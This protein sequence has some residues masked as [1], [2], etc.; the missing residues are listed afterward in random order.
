VASVTHA[1]G[2]GNTDRARGRGDGDYSDSVAAVDGTLGLCG[3][4]LAATN[5]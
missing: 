2:K 4:V 3:V 1:T 5:C